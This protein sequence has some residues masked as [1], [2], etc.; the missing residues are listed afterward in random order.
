M[1]DMNPKNALV[2]LLSHLPEV[3]RFNKHYSLWTYAVRLKHMENNKL[4]DFQSDVL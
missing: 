4:I 3:N 1:Q 2:N